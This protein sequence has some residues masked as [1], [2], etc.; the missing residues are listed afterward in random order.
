MMWFNQIKTKERTVVIMIDNERCWK[1]ECFKISSCISQIK[2]NQVKT[3]YGV[4]L[5]QRFL[6]QPSLASPV[7]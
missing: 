6:V 3:G 1:I 5:L 2:L 4:G 7:A